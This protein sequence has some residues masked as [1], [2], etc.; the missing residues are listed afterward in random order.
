MIN[1]LLSLPTAGLI[2]VVLAAVY[3]LAAIV[4]LVVLRLARGDHLANMSALSPGLLSPL[5]V[6]FGLIVAF[7]ASGIWSNASTAQ[8]SVDT[9]ASSLRAAVLLVQAFPPRTD[10][11][12]RV[13]IARQINESV[14]YEWPR[15]ADG[16]QSLYTVP[17]DA[18]AA[19]HLALSLNPRTPG[20]VEAQRELIAQLDTALDAR[21]QRII[22]SHSQVNTVK[23]FGVCLLGFILLVAI[24]CVHAARRTTA[25]LALGIFATAVGLCLIL[26]LSQDRPF[27]G[28]FA[29]KPTALIQV[30]PAT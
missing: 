9:E 18:A 24:A 7:L 10:E 17:S 6:V 11:Q 21:R 26:L 20:Q 16:T 4:L 1:W 2:A 12:M 19:V 8:S 5:G 27:S 22:V 28:P 23:W 15:L 30:R 25:I 3:V 29:I 14:R 13:L